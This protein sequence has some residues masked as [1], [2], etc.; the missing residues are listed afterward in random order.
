MSDEKKA[1]SFEQR[2]QRLND[3]VAKIEGQ[4]LPLE[5]AMS[6]YQEG[7]ELIDSLQ[8]DLKEAEAKVEESLK[9]NTE[10]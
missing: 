8:K 1:P 7:K 6:L 2:L 4:T 3:I 9:G 5:E 10:N